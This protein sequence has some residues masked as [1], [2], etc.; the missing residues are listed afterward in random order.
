MI[1][2]VLGWINVFLLILNGSLFI[3]K[4]IYKNYKFKNSKNKTKYLSLLKKIS[5]FHK[6]NGL[7]IILIAIIHAYLILGTV[8]YIHTGSILLILIIIN[9]LLYIFKNLKIFKKWLL[10]H[11][12]NTIIIFTALIIHL[13]NPWIFG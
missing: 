9:F 13:T 11:K 3:L 6:I 7:L 2:E 1:Y 4:K 12:L 10:I 8:F 5:F